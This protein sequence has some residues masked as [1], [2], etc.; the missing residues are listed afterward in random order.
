[1]IR[2]EKGAP[3]ARIEECRVQLEQ[4]LNEITLLAEKA[5]GHLHEV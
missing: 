4:S 2:I 1:M 3:S 5:V